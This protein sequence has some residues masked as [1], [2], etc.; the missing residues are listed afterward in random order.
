[1]TCNLIV[2]VGDV[3]YGEVERRGR[4]LVAY[5]CAVYRIKNITA[6]YDKFFF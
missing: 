2:P 3:T 6:A 1:M 5:F 4:I